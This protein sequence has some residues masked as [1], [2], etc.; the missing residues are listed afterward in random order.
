[1]IRPLLSFNKTE[2]ED[3]FHFE[4]S[5]NTDLGYFRNRVRNNYIPQF[6]QEN[7]KIDVALNHLADDTNYIYQALRDLTKDI[8]TT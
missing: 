7:P 8:S 2:F 5:S 4:D 3:L 1:L 6:K